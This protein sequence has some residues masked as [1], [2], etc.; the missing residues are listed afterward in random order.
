MW[1][2]VVF[3]SAAFGIGGSPA[4]LFAAEPIA[5]MV[6]FPVGE[7][8]RQ[9]NSVDIDQTVSSDA[10]PTPQNISIKL[11]AKTLLKPIKSDATGSLVEVTY[12]GVKMSE[13]VA[14]VSGEL[15]KALA[16]IVGQKITLHFTPAGRVDKVEGVDAIVAKLPAGEQQAAA[17]RFL[18]AEH[19]KEEYNTPFEQL[20]PLK[21]V[22]IGDAWDTEISLKASIAEI[23]VKSHVKFAGIDE[24]DGHKIARLEFTGTGALQP[25]AALTAHQSAVD[26]LAQNGTAQFDLTRGWLISESVDQQMKV[27][28]QLKAPGGKSVSLKIDQTVK[29]RT[30]TTP[31]TAGK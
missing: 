21:P 15:D 27:T 28:T 22:N 11:S 16:T 31:A 23:K 14:R 3:L 7:A 19:I 13:S 4:T 26:R 9:T 20:L 30:T 1:K 10:I 17:K 8:D 2:L 25:S 18:D 5:F 12:E 6:K 29:S 24:R